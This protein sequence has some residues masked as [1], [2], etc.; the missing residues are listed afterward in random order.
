MLGLVDSA[1]VTLFNLVRLLLA[2]G[3]LCLKS[4]LSKESPGQHHASVWAGAL[5][6]PLP[7]G[8]TPLEPPLL[9][10]WW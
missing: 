7:T 8:G 2:C 5:A 6:Q 4:V 1:T 9:S 3:L 10:K